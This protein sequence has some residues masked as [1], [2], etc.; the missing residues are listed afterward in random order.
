M[1]AVIRY[2]RRRQVFTWMQRRVP[3]AMMGRAMGLFMFIFFAVAPISAGLTGWI[4]R[5]FT[6]AEIFSYSGVLLICIVLLAIGNPRI[7]AIGGPLP[8]PELAEG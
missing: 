1:T 4:M 5:G 3:A 7:R 2:L 8:N 6:A